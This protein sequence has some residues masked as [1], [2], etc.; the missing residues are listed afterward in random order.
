MGYNR[1]KTELSNNDFGT[2]CFG[3]FSSRYFVWPKYVILTAFKKEEENSLM[4]IS[5]P[6]IDVFLYINTRSFSAAKDLVG[7]VGGGKI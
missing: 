4:E 7:E 2:E 6:Y 5:I 3:V 1:I